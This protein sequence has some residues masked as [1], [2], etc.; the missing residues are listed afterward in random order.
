MPAEPPRSWTTLARLRGL[1]RTSWD[2]GQLLRE[3][4]EPSGAYP[5]RRPLKR[6]TATELRNDYAA[7][8]TWAA[9]LFAAAGKYTLET[10]DVGR[11]TIGSN[12][13]PAAAVFACVEDEIAFAGKTQDSA[14]FR[15]LAAGLAELDPLLGG[16]A[17]GYPLALLDLG[18]AALTAAR[19]AIWLRDNPTPGIYVRQLSLPGVHTKFIETHRRTIDGMAAALHGGASGQG[20]P[21]ERDSGVG[22]SGAGDS[23]ADASVD[24]VGMEVSDGSEAALGDTAPLGDAAARTP[25]ARFAARHKFL[26]PPEQVRFRVLD[27]QIPT[28]GNAR[29]ITVTAEAFG[30]LSLPVRTVIATE[31][32]V[33]FLAL[34]ERPGTLALFGRGFGFSALRD[35]AWLRDCEILYWGDLDTHGF[36][37]LDQLRSVHPHVVSI[38]MD[39][40]TL[41]AHR[42]AWGHEPS[43]SRAVLT[44]LTDVESAVYDALGSDEYGPA[45]RLEQELI[46][47]DWALA[48]LLT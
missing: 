18:E 46:R 41:L 3:L 4:V 27:P 31:N 28:L 6:P 32:L 45:V 38:L 15:R 39:E 44:R 26:H 10:A 34:P 13:L 20:D 5:R 37:I 14:R 23:G 8:H 16:W 2:R 30:S 22:D 47:W 19:V 24:D 25:A 17:A 40:E 29:D 9:E 36:R 7:A 33:N 42:D 12:R 48:R 35:A 11:T 1:S 21:G 43:P